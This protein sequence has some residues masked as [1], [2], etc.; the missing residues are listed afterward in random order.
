MKQKTVQ[1]ISMLF[2]L[3]VFLCCYV[4]CYVIEECT[5]SHGRHYVYL[6]G[7]QPAGTSTTVCDGILRFVVTSCLTS[8]FL[9]TFPYT[10]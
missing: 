6:P 4:I 8:F 5:G 10:D 1:D 2:Y 7:G 3:H 9:T